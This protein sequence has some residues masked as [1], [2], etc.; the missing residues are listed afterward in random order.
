MA[1]IKITA[2]LD[3]KI[4]SSFNKI[5]NKFDKFDPMKKTR[6]GVKKTIIQTKRLENEI[7]DTRRAIL[8]LQR[9]NLTASKAQ[10]KNIKREISGHK[11]LQR[12]LREDLRLEKRRTRTPGGFQSQISGGVSKGMGGIATKMGGIGIA[13]GAATGVMT[14]GKSILDITMKME[15]LNAVLTNT[16]GSSDEAAKSMKM[17]QDIATQTPFEIDKLTE[18]YVKLVNRG[19][20]PTSEEIVKLGDLASSTGKDF[21]QL[22]E[23]L[24]DAQT[25][26][27]ER[28][29]EFGIR[30]KKDGDIVKFTFKGVTTEVQNS[31]KAI[32]DYVL[33]L[34]DVEG[35][36]G[37][38]AAIS[39]TMEGRIS[40]LRDIFTQTAATIGSKFSPVLIIGLNK[41]I[42]L[43]SS[44]AFNNALTNILDWGMAFVDNIQIAI[45]YLSTMIRPFTRIL[46]SLSGIFSIFGGVTD[47]ANA[48][49]MIMKT[50]SIVMK[51]ITFPMRVISEVISIILSVAIR[52]GIAIAKWLLKFEG[53]RKFI[54]WILDAFSNISDW[55]KGI[56]EKFTAWTGGISFLTGGLDDFNGS[57]LQTKETA[58]AVNTIFNDTFKKVIETNSVLRRIQN[59]KRLGAGIAGVVKPE[60]TSTMEGGPVTPSQGVTGKDTILKTDR[61]VKNISINIAKVNETGAITITT[62]NIKESAIR[63]QEIVNAALQQALVNATELL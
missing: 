42:D 19:F 39:A 48:L 22:A 29:K 57:L 44:G 61:S 20:K 43:L 2:V 50:V 34:G 18:S 32:T 17:L 60:P 36:T 16:L 62:Q 47:K 9:T 27:F 37:S 4:T 41:I 53:V 56:G 13:I 1:Q 54:R 40:N 5:K 55:V 63:I 6:D 49:G 25:N 3:D 33:S 12:E 10:Q 14:V 51:V 59:R 46:K 8:K 31:E 24:L 30:A 7:D 35:V 15:T 38:M 21:D 23:A 45:D 26:E 11:Q 58:A 52:I 28:L